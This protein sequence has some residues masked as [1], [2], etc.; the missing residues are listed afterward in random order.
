MA[1]TLGSS[2]GFVCGSKEIIEHQRLS[3]LAY[4]FSA[5]L[6]AMLA[7]SAIESIK[8]M[9]Q[10]PE[11]LTLLKEN[12]TLFYNTL[13]KNV[14][15]VEFYGGVSKDGKAVSPVIFIQLKTRCVDR[16][17]EEKVLQEIVDMV[18]LTHFREEYYKRIFKFVCDV[19]NSL[20]THH[21][22]LDNEGWSTCC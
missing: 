21:F 1:N 19:F 6:P 4:T 9:E 16:E 14:N 20:A 18:R 12:T 22:P 17:Q 13:I 8:I 7:V 5:S 2:G 10:E 3:G 15:Q 11:L